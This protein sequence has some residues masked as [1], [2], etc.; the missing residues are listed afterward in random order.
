MESKLTAGFA[1]MDIT[2]EKGGIPLAGFGATHLRLGTRVLDPLF[3]HAVALGQGDEAVCVMLTGDMI[4]LP[5]GIYKTMRDA[6]AEAT[7]LPAE[8]IFIGGTHTHSGPDMGSSMESMKKYRA[9]ELIPKMT[10]AARRAIADLKPAS[11][12]YGSIQ[13]GLPGAWLNFTRHYYMVEKSKLDHYTDEDRHVV[14][15]CFGNEY[16]SDKE[17]YAYV[18]HEDEADHELQ[19][20]KFARDAADDVVLLGF[21]AHATLTGGVFTPNISPDFPG[22]AVR[23][24]EELLPGTKAVYFQG[25]CGNVNANTRLPEEGIRGLTV[26]SQRDPHVYGSVLA[27]YA[28]NVLA[29][30]GSLTPSE[31][32]KVA[33]ASGVCTARRDHSMDGLLEESKKIV[34]VYNQEGN[35]PKVREMCREKGFSSVYHCTGVISKFSAPAE[36]DI[37][38][39]ALRVGDVGV[40]FAPFELFTATGKRIKAGSP[41]PM[42]LV[43]NYSCGYQGYMPSGNTYRQSYEA[44]KCPY[45]FGTADKLEEAYVDLLRSLTDEQ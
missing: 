12:S 22:A 3:L 44:I 26:G 16:A 27:A 14:G 2:P 13:A 8:T 42:T 43:K 1:R 31:T 20:V 40:V 36:G 25:C 37:P 32:D 9:E 34:A 24:L 45:E 29:T 18:G 17:H 33:V 30:P 39:R 38:L 6:V 5:D 7:G 11:L 15:D 19:V 23:R 10:E 21:A 41:F 28:M 35:T 4:L